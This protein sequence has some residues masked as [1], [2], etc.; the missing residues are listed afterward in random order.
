M[1]SKTLTI[2]AVDYESLLATNQNYKELLDNYEA[3]IVA[4]Q[5]KKNG[6]IKSLKSLADLVS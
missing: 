2:N 5:E 3:I 1:S 4:Q 6:K